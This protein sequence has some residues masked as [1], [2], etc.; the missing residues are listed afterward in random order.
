MPH[1]HRPVK[2]ECVQNCKHVV[3]EPIRRIVLVVRDRITGGS[4]SLAKAVCERLVPEMEVTVF[5][6]RAADY[7]TWRND[8][9]EGKGIENGVRVI[10]FSS[11]EERDL[12]RMCELDFVGESAA[13]ERR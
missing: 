9:P 5:T 3:A 8:L 2:V 7:V 12:V 6:S 1:E 11:A 4:E 10:R 13:L